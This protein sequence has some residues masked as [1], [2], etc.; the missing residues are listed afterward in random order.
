MWVARELGLEPEWIMEPMIE[1]MWEVELHAEDPNLSLVQECLEGNPA[2]QR[3]LFDR[4][5]PRLKSTVQRYIW[6]EVFAQDVLQEAFIRIFR[7]LHQFDRRKGHVQ[8][9]AVKIAVNTAITQGVKDS[10][11]KSR[12][13]ITFPVAE[14]PEVFEKLDQ[15]ALLQRLKVL[16]KEQYEVLLLYS[17]DGY[18]HDDIATLLGITAVTSRKRLSRAKQWIVSRFD[19]QGSEMILKKSIQ[20]E[21][22]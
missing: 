10:N 13:E 17:V 19:I 20:N 11:R 1:D 7:N 2:A 4:L 6:S 21:V 16:P 9:W 5:L 8:T 14:N 12:M 22:D 3:A 15:E 18:S